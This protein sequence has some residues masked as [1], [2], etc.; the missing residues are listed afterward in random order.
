MLNSIAIFTA[1]KFFILD[2]GPFSVFPKVLITSWGSARP[3]LLKILESFY[4]QLTG[5]RS[6][7][8]NRKMLTGDDSSV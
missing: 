6:A 2:D 4:Y 1:A 3:Y 7:D 5:L 8:R